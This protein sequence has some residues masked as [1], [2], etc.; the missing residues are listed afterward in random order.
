M[1]PWTNHFVDHFVFSFSTPLSGTASVE[2]LFLAAATKS[3]LNKYERHQ[4]NLNE[5]SNQ[6][7]IDTAEEAI[8][9]VFIQHTT[10]RRKTT[11]TTTTPT[12]Q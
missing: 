7:K 12:T 10:D 9:T 6:M 2:L 8:K 3:N 5:K 4:R 11:T 1:N